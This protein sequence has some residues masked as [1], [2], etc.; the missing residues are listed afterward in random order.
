MGSMRRVV[1]VFGVLTALCLVPG[2]VALSVPLDAE[3]VKLVQ[4]INDCALQLYSNLR[5]EEGNLVFSPYAVSSVLAAA[6]SGARGKTATKMARALHFMSDPN[7]IKSLGG[8]GQHLLQTGDKRPYEMTMASALW[9][10][11]ERSFLQE[12]I[13]SVQR[14]SATGLSEVD[15]AES[16]ASARKTVNMWM[17][18]QTSGKI[19]N[20]VPAGLLGPSPKLVLT[21][22]GSFGGSWAC[23]FNKD[24]TNDAPFSVP[25]ARPI[26]A[27]TMNQ[28][29]EFNY[30]EEKNFQGLELAYAESPL[31]LV[32]FLPKDQNGLTE[33]ESSLT[34]ENLDQWLGQLVRKPVSVYLPRFTAVRTLGMREALQAMGLADVFSAPPADLSGIDGRKDLAITELV[35]GARVE[36]SENL[37]SA[38]PVSAVEAGET[39]SVAETEFVADHPFVFLIRDRESGT[40]MFLGR[41][42]NPTE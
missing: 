17:A 5:K 31:C 11:K 36:V 19:T 42:V 10:P 39:A 27:P 32:I 18:K 29:A 20:L 12:F 34:S 35:H 6:Y 22:A 30:M 33:L 7:L 28:T 13:A 38:T 14:D 2:E 9:M 24:Y 23:P 15:F 37:S 16:P 21:S 3:Q 41:V 1:L 8:I 26:Q 25:G 40:I 4:G